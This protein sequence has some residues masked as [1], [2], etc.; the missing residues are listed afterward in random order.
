M[1]GLGSGWGGSTPR[2]VE[3]RRLSQ[4]ATFLALTGKGVVCDT[5][6]ISVYGGDAD[7]VSNI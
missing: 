7:S 4:S 1:L 5:V 3:G 6:G 2:C